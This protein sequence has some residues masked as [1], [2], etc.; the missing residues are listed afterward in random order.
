MYVDWGGHGMNEKVFEGITIEKLLDRFY[1]IL[2]FFL[3]Y[4]F[5]FLVDFTIYLLWWW[6]RTTQMTNL[7]INIFVCCCCCWDLYT[8][9]LMKEISD[10]RLLWTKE[11]DT[12]FM[13]MKCLNDYSWMSMDLDLNFRMVRSTSCDI[14]IFLF[15]FF[16]VMIN[17]DQHQNRLKILFALTLLKCPEIVY[18]IRCVKKSPPSFAVSSE[19]H[20][21]FLEKFKFQI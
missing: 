2:Y 8:G 5:F 12:I 10:D 15:H 1:S 13:L 4:F 18:K 14:H 19:T 9:R 16:F 6:I 20:K 21:T 7:F 3:F 11:S 17:L